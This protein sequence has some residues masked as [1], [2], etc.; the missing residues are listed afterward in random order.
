MKRSFITSLILVSLFIIPIVLSQ[1]SVYTDKSSY[2]K[3]ET[4][5]IEGAGFTPGAAVSVLIQDSSGAEAYANQ[6]TVNVTGGFVTKPYT[7]PESR[8]TGTW[9]LSAST[10]FESDQH[11]F[12]VLGDTEAPLYSNFGRD[13]TVVTNLDDVQIS[14]TWE[15]NINMGNIM[16]W[17]DSTGS[18]VGHV[19]GP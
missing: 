5:Y 8:P 14:V 17:E 3:L 18:W 16:I 12:D 13:K 11:T 1:V 15:D 7:I 4:V 9:T 19:V 10:E 6:T 2:N